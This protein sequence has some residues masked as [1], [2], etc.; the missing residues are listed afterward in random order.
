[1]E[2]KIKSTKDGVRYTITKNNCTGYNL[3][4]YTIQES[5]KETMR[6]AYYPNLEQ[7]YNRIIYL[8]LDGSDV[9]EIKQAMEKAV[10]NIKA[11]VM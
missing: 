11:G 6:V 1:M 7:I 9:I 2:L 10:T 8:D 4:T 3:N 5:G